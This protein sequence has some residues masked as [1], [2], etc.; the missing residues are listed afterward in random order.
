MIR[1][2]LRTAQNS[3]AAWLGTVLS[4]KKRVNLGA[5]RREGKWAIRDV[6]AVNQT[7]GDSRVRFLSYKEI[8]DRLDIVDHGHDATREHEQAGDDRENA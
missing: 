7:I 2:R 1:S 3:P 6:V 5:C 8:I 4:L